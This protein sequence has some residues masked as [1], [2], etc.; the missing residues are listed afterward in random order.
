MKAQTASI[1]ITLALFVGCASQAEQISECRDK[2]ADGWVVE[3]K[4]DVD[5]LYLFNP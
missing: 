3:T 4:T 1:I 2:R 5:C